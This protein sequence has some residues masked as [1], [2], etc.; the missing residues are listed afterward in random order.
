MES[1]TFSFRRVVA[2]LLILLTLYLVLLRKAASQRLYSMVQVNQDY[3]AL[4]VTRLDTI[5]SRKF[6]TEHTI[7]QKHPRDM[8]AELRRRSLLI[9]SRRYLQLQARIQGGRTRRPL[10]FGRQKI[11]KN[12]FTLICNFTHNRLRKISVYGSLIASSTQFL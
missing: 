1:A 7:E 5:I 3:I 10:I 11:F 9:I 6:F 8:S 2:Q 4:T 12:S